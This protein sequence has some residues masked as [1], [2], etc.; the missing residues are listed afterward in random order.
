ME[1]NPKILLIE[2]DKR[3]SDSLRNGLERK[4]FIVETAF[5]GFVGARLAISNHFDLILLDIN[6]PLMN[7]FEVCK[8]IRQQNI[9]TPIL[10]LTAL[11]EIDDKV[12]GF[13]SGADDYLVKPFELRELMVRIQALLRR[14]SIQ[15]DFSS[16]ILREAN[17]MM[18]LRSKTVTRNEKIIELT[19][20]EF[21]L[22]EYLL[23]NK[24][25]VLSKMD[26]VENVWDLNFDTSTNIV[27]VYINYLRK[28]IDREFEP[29]LVHTKTGL[30][31]V[32]K[33]L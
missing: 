28:K 31:Y 5:D 32:L 10:M 33:T 9:K 8:A 16:E 24:G 18:D 25:R 23:R 12:N 30:G 21:E 3:V 13:E 11:G 22:L 15:Q 27:E 26:I 19:A 20:R 6:L 4:D 17:L 14:T 7:G 2:D 1:N 29:K